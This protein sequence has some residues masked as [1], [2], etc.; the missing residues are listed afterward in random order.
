MLHYCIWQ[1][2]KSWKVPCGAN[3]TALCACCCPVQERLPDLEKLRAEVARVKRKVEHYK[4]KYKHELV[5]D[6][7]DYR[8][9]NE[10]KRRGRPSAPAHHGEAVQPGHDSHNDK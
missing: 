8:T 7:S 5:T 6:Q 4:D 2:C 1:Q 3:A 9:D 10:G